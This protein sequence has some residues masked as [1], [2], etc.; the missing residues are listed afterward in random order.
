MTLLSAW[1]LL[2]ALSL[3]ALGCHV[4]MGKS[5]AGVDTFA[6]PTA[7][8]VPLAVAPMLMGMQSAP[9]CAPASKAS[10]LGEMTIVHTAYLV[11][12]PQKTF[13][14]EAGIAAKGKD[15]LA[16]FSL[17]DRLALDFEA[18]SS[19]GKN[20]ADLR[21]SGWPSPSFVLLTHAHWDHTSGLLDLDHPRVILGPGEE[22]FWKNIPKDRPPV[23]MVHHSAGATLESFS[24]DGP[25]FE[26]FP[27]S[28]DLFG[29]GSV[30]LV[31]LPGH[32][33]G[34]L[35]VFLSS[36]QG[37][38]VLFVGDTAWSHEA[39]E[40]PSH[41]LKL[42]S[43]LTD[44]NTSQ[45]SESLWKL[46]ALKQRYPD[47]LIVPTHDGDAFAALSRLVTGHTSP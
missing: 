22:Q 20:L 16:R 8:G 36:V 6:P 17:L 12:H 21:R 43:D 34:S 32:T 44:S 31:P 40:L 19:T 29:D 33:P 38:R 37:R 18:T 11:Q 7:T 13:Q 5:P 35:G 27:S 2:S 45:L 39:F 9:R 10:C 14:I 15:D 30:V 3:L 28:H 25:A 42:M 23:A 4:P 47:L 26:N 1:R 46:H 24:W 41:K